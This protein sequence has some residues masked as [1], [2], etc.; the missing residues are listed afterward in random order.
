MKWK[1]IK[2]GGEGGQG[3]IE[4]VSDGSGKLGALKRLHGKNA[5][6][7]NIRFRFHNEA[8]ALRQINIVGV[9]KLIESQT[10]NWNDP[11]TDLFYVSE[12]IEG[13]KL[14]DW[15]RKTLPTLRRC[16]EII[17]SL[18]HSV[19]HIHELGILHRDIKPDNIMICDNRNI[20]LI[21]FGMSKY[22]LANDNFKTPKQVELGNRF[23]RLPEYSSGHHAFDESSDVTQIVGIFFYLLTGLY[24]RILLDTEGKLPHQRVDITSFVETKFANQVTRIF[25]IGFQYHKLKRFQSVT[26]LQSLLNELSELLNGAIMENKNSEADEITSFFNSEFLR[27][28]ENRESL[29]KKI[30]NAYL[31]KIS[32]LASSID[33]ACAGSEYCAD[34]RFSYKSNFLLHRR[35]TSS[36]KSSYNHILIWD[37]E[38]IKLSSQGENYSSENYFISKSS[39][40][41][42]LTQAAIQKAESD[43]IKIAVVLKAKFEQI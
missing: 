29:M 22:E 10:D 41:I 38:I 21:D 9:P 40:I 8:E 6:N 18:L 43:F 19:Q 30:N 17:H 31:G 39:D 15:R 42:G 34:D 7:T 5:K 33:L 35:G 28:I 27:E 12:W 24:P 11:A 2:K 14:D 26:E 16:L 36:P 20:Y 23:L 25:D 1:T 3:F 32:Q 4:K 13:Y 37:D